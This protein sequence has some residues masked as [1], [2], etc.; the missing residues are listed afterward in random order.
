[1]A[2]IDEMGTF[3]AVADNLSETVN[4]VSFVGLSAKVRELRDGKT[5]FVFDI[6]NTIISHRGRR[7]PPKSYG[8]TVQPIGRLG[9]GSFFLE[10]LSHVL[11]GGKDWTVLTAGNNLSKYDWFR[12]AG[13]RRPLSFPDVHIE[14]V[15]SEDKHE[16]VLKIIKTLPEPYERVVFFDDLETAFDDDPPEELLQFLVVKYDPLFAKTVLSKSLE[17]A[18]G[19]AVAAAQLIHERLASHPNKDFLIK[20]LATA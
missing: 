2:S 7:D 16:Q 18:E 20:C 14:C 1:M 13:Q 6:D 4:V 15:D 10:D 5:L 12:L 17:K 9:T 19:N 3:S 11:R 8:I